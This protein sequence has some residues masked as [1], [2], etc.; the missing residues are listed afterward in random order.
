M[1]NKNSPGRSLDGI[2][3]KKKTFVFFL[4]LDPTI[5]TDTTTKFFLHVDSMKLKFS[6]SSP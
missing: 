3:G 2:T 1:A 5:A 6:I 4:P